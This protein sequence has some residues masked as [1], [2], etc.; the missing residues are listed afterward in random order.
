LLGTKDHSISPKVMRIMLSN[1]KS[2]TK[3]KNTEDFLNYVQQHIKLA[4][5]TNEDVEQTIYLN[6]L[7][8]IRSYKYHKLSF[9]HFVTF[10]LPRRVMQHVW[11]MTKD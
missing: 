8:L 10:L 3:I 11:K 6:L 2:T 5:M 4:G 1:M 9:L 7:S